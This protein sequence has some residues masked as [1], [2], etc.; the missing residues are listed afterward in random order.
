MFLPIVSDG[1]ILERRY[2]VLLREF[3][4]R[5]GSGGRGAHN[6]GDGVIREIEFLKVTMSNDHRR[7]DHR[8]SHHIAA[9]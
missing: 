4:I 9:I 1:E 2:N 3:S 8:C 5:R 6:G 7:Y